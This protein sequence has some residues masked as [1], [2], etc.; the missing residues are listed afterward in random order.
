MFAEHAINLV[1]FLLPRCFVLSLNRLNI[2]IKFDFNSF[3]LAEE[4]E[5]TAAVSQSLLTKMEQ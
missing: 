2:A 4:L 3:S 1:A 5:L